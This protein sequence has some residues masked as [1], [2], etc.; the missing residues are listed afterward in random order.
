M[1]HTYG[2]FVDVIIQHF[3]HLNNVIV[4]PNYAVYA[5]S[6]LIDGICGLYELKGGFGGREKLS[7]GQGTF[8]EHGV[9][10]KDWSNWWMNI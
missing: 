10:I 1:G 9:V 2:P 6:V 4:W 3:D 5:V 8:F 7:V